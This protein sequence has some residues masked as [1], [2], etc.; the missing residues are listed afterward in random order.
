MVVVVVRYSSIALLRRGCIDRR[1]AAR[2]DEVFRIGDLRGE[3]VLGGATEIVVV[4]VVEVAA[5]VLRPLAALRGNGSH[6]G[7]TEP[8]RCRIAG[9]CRRIARVDDLR[10]RDPS[11]GELSPD[12]VSQLARGR[13]ICRALRRQDINRAGRP[14]HIVGR[15]AADQVALG[16]GQAPIGRGDR[17][18]NRLFG[19]GHHDRMAG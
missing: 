11:V 8:D 17:N 13:R 10:A 18:I 7:E 9:N 6:A 2:R 12:L 5:D 14:G 4:L 15:K 19:L 3:I 16:D 1:H